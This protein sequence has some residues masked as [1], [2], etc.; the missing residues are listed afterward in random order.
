MEDIRLILVDIDGTLLNSRLEVTPLTRKAIHRLKE[1]NIAFGIATGRSPYAVKN[2]IRDWGLDDC[3]DLILGFNGSSTLYLDTME[4]E[5]VHMLEG[6]A[7]RQIQE[8]F[9]D[10]D[11][12]IGI[13]DKETYHALREDEIARRTAANN[14]FTLIIEDLTGY[15]DKQVSKLLLMGEEHEITRMMEYYEKN[16]HSD[17]YHL[18]RSAK[19]LIE[20]VNPQISKSKGIELITKRLGIDK[21][22]VMTFG[23]MMN[24]YEM[25]RDYVGVAM[26]N[27]DQRIKDA[28]RYVTASNE[29]DGIAVIIDK[30]IKEKEEA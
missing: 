26:G 9:R 3:T 25:I 15:A 12:N 18:F 21:E 28:A 7:I 29:E 19:V 4:M 17:F 13:Y 14:H 27:G 22:Q 1:H 5:T 23:D 20:C 2:L 16:I 6:K 8:D 10:F 30:L 24:D 11:F